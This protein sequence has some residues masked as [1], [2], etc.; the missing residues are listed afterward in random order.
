MKD[1]EFIMKYIDI[2]AADGSAM[3]ISRIAMGSTM[4]MEML[5]TEEK[6]RLYDFF[7]EQG[8][9][10]L[11]TARYYSGGRA[12]TMIGDYLSARKNRDK[13][14][15]CTKGGHPSDDAPDKSRLSRKEILGDLET[16][17][18][19]LSTDY[20]DIFWI[21]KDD[22]AYP[23]EDLIDT[24]NEI[25]KQGKARKIGCS[26]F[27]T[28]RIAAANAYASANGLIGFTSSQIQWSLAASDDRHFAQFGSIV[29]TP[30]RYDYY[31]KHDIP[32][33]S[34]SSQ[35]QGFFSKVEKNGLE[36]L[37]P[38][39]AEQY[40]SEENMKRLENLK[41]FCNEKGC[42]IASASLAYLLN[43]K[44][45]CVAII[46]ARSEEMLADSLAAVD[47]TMTAEQADD[48]FRV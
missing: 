45:P 24:C 42:S 40:G 29:M 8:G 33:F 37:P 18:K 16:S 1:E 43:N 32:V 9:N 28:P 34:F 26:N 47:V 19:E 12:E 36:S 23:I 30:E 10:C 38:H 6:H 48:L 17:L 44:L 41:T 21:H 46:G 4:K 20:V 2:P 22:P 39:L 27:V 13:L 3:H 5:T 31:L 14:I 15:I 11:D 7:V 35:A 25:V